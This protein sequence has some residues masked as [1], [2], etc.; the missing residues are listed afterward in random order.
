MS[1]VTTVEITKK[2]FAKEPERYIRSAGPTKLVVVKNGSKVRFVIGG[3][4]SYPV[5]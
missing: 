1:K 2:Q 4:L 3:H 5:G